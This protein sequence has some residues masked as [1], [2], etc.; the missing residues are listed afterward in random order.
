MSIAVCWFPGP[1]GLRQYCEAFKSYAGLVQV[2][3]VEAGKT[4]D[5]SL[6]RA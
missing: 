1:A 4:L 5:P 2:T 6:F 3:A